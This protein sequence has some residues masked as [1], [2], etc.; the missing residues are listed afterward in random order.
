MRG[1]ELEQCPFINPSARKI[2][3][4]QRPFHPN[5]HWKGRIE[6]VSKQQNTIGDFFSDTAQLHQLQPRFLITH[7]PDRLQIQFSIRDVPRG[8]Q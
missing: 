6:S 1:G 2:Q 5:I 7:L 8:G 3:R 4:P